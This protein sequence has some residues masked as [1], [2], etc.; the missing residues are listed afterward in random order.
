MQA[1]EPEYCRKNWKKRS[2]KRHSY[3]LVRQLSHYNP[4]QDKTHRLTGSQM[5]IPLN[6][7][8]SCSHL[9]PSI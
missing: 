9:Y 3:Q 5:A 8:G 7:G 4:H 6:M 1:I 2:K